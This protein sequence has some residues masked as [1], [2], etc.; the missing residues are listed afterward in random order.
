M[1]ELQAHL[2]ET[3]SF[4]LTDAR[5]VAFVEPWTNNRNFGGLGA[6]VRK[7]VQYILYC[8]WVWRLSAFSEEKK[9]RDREQQ[10]LRMLRN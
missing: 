4:T 6:E 2:F 7:R 3:Q 8:C 1:S 9:R 5:S 10:L